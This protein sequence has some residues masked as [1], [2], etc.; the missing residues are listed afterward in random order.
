MLAS[1]DHKV[2][3]GALQMADI[4]MKKLPAVFS[5]YF[6]RQG[7]VHQIKL[8]SGSSNNVSDQTTP[9]TSS[10]PEATTSATSPASKTEVGLVDSNRL[11]PYHLCIAT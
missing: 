11:A 9:N 1:Q 7:V 10:S 6:Q 8:L 2:V 4:L 5:Q 3:V